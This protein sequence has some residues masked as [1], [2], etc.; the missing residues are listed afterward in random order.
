MIILFYK[1][2]PGGK[3]GRKIKSGENTLEDGGYGY[4]SD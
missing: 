4:L 3:V 1:K 2:G